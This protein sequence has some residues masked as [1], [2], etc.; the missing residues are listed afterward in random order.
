MVPHNAEAMLLSVQHDALVCRRDL[1]IGVKDFHQCV[2]FSTAKNKEDTRN[3]SD[4]DTIFW[5]CVKIPPLHI[6]PYPGDPPQTYQ[7]VPPK[8]PHEQYRQ[9][10]TRPAPQPTQTPGGRR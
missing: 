9:Q 2:L 4:P 7:E 5:A 3:P 10:P 8:I 1:C 6:I